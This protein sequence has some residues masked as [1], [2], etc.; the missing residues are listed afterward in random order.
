MVAFIKVR[1]EPVRKRGRLLRSLSAAGCRRS[2]HLENRLFCGRDDSLDVFGVHAVGGILGAI[3]TG[4]LV[5]PDLGGSGLADYTTS[6]G[7][8]VAGAYDMTTQ[9]ITQAKAV[10]FTVLW[11]GIISAILFKLVDILIGLRPVTDKEREGL[12]ITDHGERAYNY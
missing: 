4:I 12:D 5:S 7:T 6:P 2:R 11:T 1:K 3:G 10:G 8:L 9:V